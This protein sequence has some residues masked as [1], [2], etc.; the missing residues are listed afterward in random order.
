MAALNAFLQHKGL[1]PPYNSHHFLSASC[2][3]PFFVIEH[4]DSSFSN[5]PLSGWET[6]K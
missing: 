3:G 2:L 4:L 1:I 6:L 5:I